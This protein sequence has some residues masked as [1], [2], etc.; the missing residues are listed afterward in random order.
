MWG[1]GS[2]P[3]HF[4]FA[5]LGSVQNELGVVPYCQGYVGC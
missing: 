5:P 3:W 4:A 2:N 1:A